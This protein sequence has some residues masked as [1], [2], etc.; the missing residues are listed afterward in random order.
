MKKNLFL[1]FVL[2]TTL[3][4]SA[5]ENI[6]VEYFRYNQDSAKYEL[7]KTSLRVYDVGVEPLLHFDSYIY[8]PLIPKD[9]YD[10]V[11]YNLENAKVITESSVY[12]L[13]TGYFY[14]DINFVFSY[15]GDTTS[16]TMIYDATIVNKSG[17]TTLKVIG[18]RD[19]SLVYI[20]E[21]GRQFSDSYFHDYTNEKCQIYQHY[22]FTSDK[23]SILF[24]ITECD[25][26]RGDTSFGH[27]YNDEDTTIIKIV[28]DSLNRVL[29]YEHYGDIG[30]N[31]D[32]EIL[33]NEFLEDSIY[34]TRIRILGDSVTYSS[35]YM[36]SYS[37]KIE[38]EGIIEYDEKGYL[39][40]LN[41]FNNIQR[42]FNENYSLGY[43]IDD[44]TKLRTKVD[45]IVMHR[46]YIITSSE[47]SL[48]NKNQSEINIFPNPSTGIINIQLENTVPFNAE[49]FDI[50]GRSI[51]KEEG[52][53]SLQ[54][55]NLDKG[56][57]IIKLIT[58]QGVSTQRIEVF[59]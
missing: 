57:Y 19:D 35:S 48:Q 6:L 25:S 56:S 8:H 1:I 43:K 21:E 26:I 13:D 47:K 7:K 11:T 23:W 3:S 32:T 33:T 41:L 9:P 16:K 37:L 54:I 28:T 39:S 55:S 34:V 15:R 22:S 49:V 12:K 50:Q 53:G 40:F 24:E 29:R 51:R 2:F 14:Q 27:I 38:I 10:D 36:R 46:N 20:A 45:S 44:E 4:V 18:G 17:D 59:E 30:F 58:S 31:S 5:Q 52:L 42:D